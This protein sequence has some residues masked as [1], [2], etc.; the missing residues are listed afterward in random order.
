MI[1]ST[2]TSSDTQRTVHIIVGGC[3]QGVWFRKSF[4]EIAQENKLQGWVRNRQDGSVEAFVLGTKS[5]TNVLKNEL[6][7]NYQKKSP[8]ARVDYVEW[9]EIDEGSDRF[10]YLQSFTDPNNAF[11]IA[12]SI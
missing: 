5:A 10:N 2:I 12:D 4:A 3:V 1:E 9:N 8:N 11:I 6:H 7:H